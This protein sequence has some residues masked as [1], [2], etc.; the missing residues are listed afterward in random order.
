[1][2]AGVK[3]QEVAVYATKASKCDCGKRRSRKQ[4]FWQ[5]I[6]PFNKNAAGQPKSRAEIRQELAAEAMAWEAEPIT[7]SACRAA[8]A[9]A[10]A[11]P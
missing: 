6:N 5:T 3:F 4:K 8:I 2:S 11:R 9:K 10:G 1:M 7:C